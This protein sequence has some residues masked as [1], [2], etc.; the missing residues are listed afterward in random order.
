[1]LLLLSS[2]CEQENNKR[3]QISNQLVAFSCPFFLCQSIKSVYCY[4][5]ARVPMSLGA[6]S[7]SIYLSFFSF[8]LSSVFCFIPSPP[9]LSTRAKGHQK[10]DGNPNGNQTFLPSPFRPSSLFALAPLAPTRLYNPGNR[11]A[12][13]RHIDNSNL[14]DRQADKDRPQT[15]SCPTSTMHVDRRK[16][17]RQLDRGRKKRERGEWACAS[18]CWK[19]EKGEETG[20]LTSSRPLFARPPFLLQP[21]FSRRRREGMNMEKWTAEN[22][23]LIPNE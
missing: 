20:K 3:P 15:N 22:P 11:N 18:V 4:Y 9:Y 17:E 14:R 10:E 19:V 5:F 16:R 23:L 7:L 2:S 8:S 12:G 6:L 1:M 13:N 21:R